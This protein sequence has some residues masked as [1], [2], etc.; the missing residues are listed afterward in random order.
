MEISKETRKTLNSIAS[1]AADVVVVRGREFKIRWI[2][3]DVN[4]KINSLV[5]TEDKKERS[6]TIHKVFTLGILNSFFKIKFF[7]PL[8]WRWFYYVKGY[9]WEELTPAIT[10]I[11]KKIPLAAF[12]QNMALSV[13]MMTSW[14]AMEKKEADQYRQELMLAASQLLEKNTDGL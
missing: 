8:L 1:D 6:Q 5:D 13:E 9:T 2:R 14:R 4:W 12:W 7:Y 10:L 11:K 3:P